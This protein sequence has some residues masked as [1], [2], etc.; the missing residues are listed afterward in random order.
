MFGIQGDP[1]DL[2]HGVERAVYDSSRE[3]RERSTQLRRDNSAE[4]HNTASERDATAHERDLS[5][6]V[7][8]R[9]AEARDLE[10]DSSDAEIASLTRRAGTPPPTARGE[11][12]LQAAH[13][14]RRAAS[15]RARSAIHRVEAGRDRDRAAHDRLLSADDRRSAAADRAQAVAESEADEV[16]MLT[17]A[18]RRAPGLADMQRE[19]DRAHR[20]DGQ[21]IA[22]Y[23]DVDGLKATNDTKGHHA[24]D[25][26]LRH[27]VDVLQTNLRSYES[28]VRLGGDEFVCT[29]SDTKLENVRRRFAEITAELRL[30]PDDGSITVGFAELQQGDSPMDLIDRADNELMTSRR[31]QSHERRAGS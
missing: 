22:A 9:D 29:I 13:D 18:R 3:L 11:I 30:T 25:V 28:V 31:T 24:G 21:L 16:D 1:E 7:R 19:I 12:I 23:V 2:G 6:L 17:G 10:D 20:G 4:R 15:D 26:M 8:D 5:A 14:R 27:I